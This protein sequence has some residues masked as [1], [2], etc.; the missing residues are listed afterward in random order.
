MLIA[1]Q[2]VAILLVALVVGVYWGPWVAL[3]RSLAQFDVE[4]FLPVVTRLNA[5]LSGLMTVLVPVAL[6]AQVGLLV[7]EFWRG[8]LPFTLA[9]IAFLLFVLTVAVTVLV[10]VPIVKQIVTWQVE[11]VPRTWRELRDRWVSFHLLR[12]I[13]GLVAL[14]L[15]VTAAIL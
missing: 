12:V 10:E 15:Y 13:P 9:A 8:A 6:L 5:N 11:T 14:M 3:T 2:L 4:V 7:V 1:V